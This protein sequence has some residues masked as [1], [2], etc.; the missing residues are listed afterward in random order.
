[1]TKDGLDSTYGFSIINSTDPKGLNIFCNDNYTI[2]KKQGIQF[3]NPHSGMLTF[4]S[5]RSPSLPA[6][7]EMLSTYR[8]FD[9]EV[10]AFDDGGVFGYV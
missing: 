5:D 8:F 2:C 6:S 3:Q 1:M 4:M 7:V 10:F 9:D